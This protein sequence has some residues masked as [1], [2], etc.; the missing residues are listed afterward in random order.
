MRPAVLLSGGA[1]AGLLGVLALHASPHLGRLTQVGSGA[2]ASPSVA[3]TTGASTPSTGAS[4]PAASGTT[5]PSLHDGTV[6]GPPVQYG[7]GQLSVSVA[8]S[9][10]RIT[11]V[12][13]TGLQTAEQYSS[14]LAAQVIPVLRGEVLAAQS[15]NINSLS[16]ATYTCEAY[17]QSLQAA[18]DKLRA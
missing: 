13:V 9:G 3:P 10:H 7:Y 16:G 2:A 11:A 6:T 15:A 17:A 14:Q 1:C 4:T 18:L 5:A 12:N 8:V